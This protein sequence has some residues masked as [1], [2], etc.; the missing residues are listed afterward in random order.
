[1]DSSSN[2]RI[3]LM[4]N[5]LRG[6]RI[7]IQHEIY[8]WRSRRVRFCTEYDSGGR[9][10]SQWHP[11]RLSRRNDLVILGILDRSTSDNQA[12]DRVNRK[13]NV[14]N[15]SLL[16]ER[17]FPALFYSSLSSRWSC[18]A[19]DYACVLFNEWVNWRKVY[20]NEM[21]AAHGTLVI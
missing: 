3:R 11:S 5:G 16:W 17:A 21:H 20:L 18:L 15:K 13:A 9:R 8:G 1:M 2:S 7:I 14:I 10:S 12:V 19:R 6:T 4:D